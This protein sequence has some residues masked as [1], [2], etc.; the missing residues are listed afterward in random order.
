MEKKK[1]IYQWSRSDKTLHLLSALPLIVFYVGTIYFL[2]LHSLYLTRT[3][4]NQQ[5]SDLH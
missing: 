2:A 3:S 4:R 1:Q 5:G